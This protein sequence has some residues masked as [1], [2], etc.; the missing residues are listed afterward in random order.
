M[1]FCEAHCIIDKSISMETFVY[2]HLSFPLFPSIVR[3]RVHL[4]KCLDF[5]W[6]IWE[7][8]Q[9]LTNDKHYLYGT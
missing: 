9:E 8:N 5:Y 4:F 2:K 3:V 1:T 6:Y 7:L